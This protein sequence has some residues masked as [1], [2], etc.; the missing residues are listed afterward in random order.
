[1]F[2]AFMGPVP[3]PRREPRKEPPRRGR[4]QNSVSRGGRSQQVWFAIGVIGS[5][6]Y[7]MGLALLYSVG[8]GR[9]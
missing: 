7:L 3:T 5:I 9:T 6:G 1:M 2:M 8:R 4:P